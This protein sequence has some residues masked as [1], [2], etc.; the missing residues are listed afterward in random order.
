LL[1]QTDGDEATIVVCGDDDIVVTGI[2][3]GDSEVAG[4]LGALDP[5]GLSNDVDIVD[6][7]VTEL[8]TD[9]E[10]VFG[11]HVVV[12]VVTD[13]GLPS[14]PVQYRTTV[15]VT[16]CSL[17]GQA[18]GDETAAVVSGDDDTVVRGLDGDDNVVA[19]VETCELVELSADDT[20]ETEVNDIEIEL[21]GTDVEVVGPHVVVTVVIVVGLPSW[22]VVEST[23]VSV[24]ICSLLGQAD[25]DEI[26]V[27]SREEL[28]SGTD[29]ASELDKGC[30]GDGV[31]TVVD[32]VDTVDG[33]DVE[34]VF[35]PQVLVTVVTV[36]GLP[37]SPVQYRT[38]V[39]VTICSLFGQAD[40]DE[41]AAVVSGDDDSVAIGLDGADNVVASV[42]TCE[43]VELSVDGTVKTEVNGVEIE[44]DSEDVEDVF[45]P[46]VLVTV[47]TVVGLPSSPVQYRTTVS[48]TICSLLGQADGDETAAVVSGEELVSGTDAASELDEGCEGDGVST[49]VDAVGGVDVEDVFGPQVLVTVVTVVGLPSSPVQ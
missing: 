49:D 33:A 35:G 10:D 20:V 45:G 39:S 27:V 7:L 18:D 9:E 32:G 36:V 8:G 30:E 11:P 4:E 14:S 42:V 5:L 43:L 37:S 31:N 15:S 16:I 21:D 3:D 25:S 41:T 24:T 22:P 13:V 48:V 2:E 12:T 19:S 1:G 38:T 29:E 23:I 46:Q 34:D 47:V 26:V 44:L 6:A 17:L 28:V 40:G